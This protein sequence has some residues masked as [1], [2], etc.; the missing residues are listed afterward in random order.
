MSVKQEYSNS[1][2][3]GRGGALDTVVDGKTGILFGDQTVDA[4]CDAITK[5]EAMSFDPD[6]IF[7][8]A[9]GFSGDVFKQNVASLL[10]EHG[11]QV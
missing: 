2:L 7:D 11:I 4:L 5:F 10:S 1:L 3:V 6:A 8:H 9:T